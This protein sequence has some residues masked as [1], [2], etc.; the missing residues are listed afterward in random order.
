MYYEP[1]HRVKLANVW[2]FRPRRWGRKSVQ[3]EALPGLDLYNGLS[4]RCASQLER[5]ALVP[6]SIFW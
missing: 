4:I 5:P 3:A 1:D 2:G 6:K